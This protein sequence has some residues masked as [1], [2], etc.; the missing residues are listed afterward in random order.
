MGTGGGWG[1]GSRGKDQEVVKG[2]DRNGL[3]EQ[4]GV[5]MGVG[6][7]RMGLKG[8]GGGRKG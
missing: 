6:G 8:A 5:G 1:V 7:C 4:E 2:S 3:R